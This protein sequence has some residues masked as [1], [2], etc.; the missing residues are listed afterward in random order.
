MRTEGRRPAPGAE[1]GGREALARLHRF[2]G[3]SLVRD[4]SAILL[5]DVP[6]RLAAARAGV[7]RG[8]ARAVQLA[9]HSVKSSCA[10]FGAA[11][12][13]VLCEEAERAA[14]GDDLAGLPALLDRIEEGFASFRGWLEREVALPRGRE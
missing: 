5:E 9:V 6:P 2:G 10:Q 14:R 3:E 8:D 1:D 13:A 7:R 4:L 12:V 11:T